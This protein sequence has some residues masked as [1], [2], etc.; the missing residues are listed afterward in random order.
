MANLEWNDVD[1]ERRIIKIIPKDG[2]SPKG[3][4]GG[5]IPINDELYELLLKQREKYTGNSVVERDR[6]KRYDRALWQNFW[7]VAKKLGIKDVNI[8]T[9]RHAFASYLIMSGVDLGTVKEL[10]GPRDITT[11][12]RYVHLKPSHKHWAV[13]KLCSI[14]RA[15]TI[16]S[17]S[18][19]YVM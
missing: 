6:V 14:S 8:H 4:R 12:M 5:E 2:W 3:K 18:K 17:Q 13:N 19:K 15:G 9:F 11:T 7:R 16:W 1:F 10:L